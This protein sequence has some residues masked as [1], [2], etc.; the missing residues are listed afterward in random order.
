VNSIVEPVNNKKMNTKNQ[1]EVNSPDK[2]GFAAAVDAVIESLYPG[3]KPTVPPEAYSDLKTRIPVGEGELRIAYEDL[4][5]RWKLENVPES[6]IDVQTVITSALMASP[7]PRKPTLLTPPVQ[8]GAKTQRLQTMPPP[9]VPAPSVKVT[10]SASGA[11]TQALR[12][13]TPPSKPPGA[14]G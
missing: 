10:P 12:P 2:K 1:G 6:P 7:A 13:S 3:Q 9:A 11:T 8:A 5:V 14:E 4:K